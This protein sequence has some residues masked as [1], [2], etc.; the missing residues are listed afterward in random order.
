MFVSQN[1]LLPAPHLA[2]LFKETLLHSDICLMS[3][4]LDFSLLSAFSRPAQIRWG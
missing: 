1:R 2:S 3:K 4:W